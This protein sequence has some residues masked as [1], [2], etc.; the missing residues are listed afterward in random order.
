MSCATCVISIYLCRGRR[1]PFAVD[2]YVSRPRSVIRQH[3]LQNGECVLPTPPVF[4]NTRRSLT[5]TT[6]GGLIQQVHIAC[7]M[8]LNKSLLRFALTT[9]KATLPANCLSA[10]CHYNDR[11][12]NAPAEP[13]Q[14]R[15][16]CRSM[17]A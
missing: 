5:I 10:L 13:K 6:V 11:V 3:I 12:N 16:L 8:L 7:I 9:L 14:A 1:S 15:T 2:P 4:E 17:P